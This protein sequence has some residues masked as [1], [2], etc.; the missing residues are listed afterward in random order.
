M[1]TKLRDAIRKSRLN[2]DVSPEA[3]WEMLLDM[4]NKTVAQNI[5]KMEEIITQKTAELQSEFDEKVKVFLKSIDKT[6]EDADE[7]LKNHIATRAVEIQGP[8]GP[9]GLQGKSIRG[10]QGKQGK[11]GKAGVGK[12]GDSGK[13]GSPDK[14]KEIVKKLESLTGDDRLDKSAIK[15]LQEEFSLLSRSLKQ[16]KGGGKGGG[17]G[18]MG[19]VQHER[20]QIS[21]ATTTIQTNFKIAGGGFA[22]WTYYNE[23]MIARSVDYTVG[24]DGKTITLLFTPQDSTVID[25][26]YIRS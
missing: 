10:P 22:L 17:G 15:G 13:D 25:V 2:K 6:K 14:P 18:G 24:G 23:G 21:S 9:R 20:K 26:I 8:K 19:N 5:A 1:D 16:N 12:K 4:V 3:M 11:P 7:T